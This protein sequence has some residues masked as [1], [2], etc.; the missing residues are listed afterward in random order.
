MSSPL[1]RPRLLSPLPCVLLD[2]ETS[3]AATETSATIAPPSAPDEPSRRR[4]ILP[5]NLARYVPEGQQFTEWGDLLWKLFGKLDGTADMSKYNEGLTEEEID[6]T[7]D[8]MF[9]KLGG[10][11][12]DMI[13]YHEGLTQ[14]EIDETKYRMLTSHTLSWEM[15]NRSC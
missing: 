2:M 9:G 11:T 13:K 4:R 3:S 10:T 12:A 7:M 5:A 1:E 6:E 8:R 14:E 15:A